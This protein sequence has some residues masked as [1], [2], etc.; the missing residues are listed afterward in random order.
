MTQAPNHQSVLLYAPVETFA[1]ETGPVALALD[2]CGQH[3]LPLTAVMLTAAAAF[4]VTPEGR[5]QQQLTQDSAELEVK[6]QANTAAMT[7]ACAQSG[8]DLNT[9]TEIDYSRGFMPFVD[10]HAR[11]HSLAVIG[12]RDAGPLSE[13]HVSENLLFEAGRPV[14]LVPGTHAARFAARKIAV[15][16][17]NSRPAA[18]AL[19]DALALLPGVE[20]L[21]LIAIGDEKAIHTSIS[22]EQLVQTLSRRGLSVSNVQRPVGGRTIGQALQ[23]T[24]LEAGADLLVM[25]A[26]GHS[27]MRQFFL[28]GATLGVLS[29]LRL[30]VLMAH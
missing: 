17:D 5:T 6:N 1:I 9:V 12:T 4:T 2:L 21:V 18:R 8:I 30:P 11:L 29:N 19:G 10:D 15:A 14:L 23:E 7:Q 25:G 24:A 13:R 28:G 27:R 26:Y 16:W 22:S 3:G 20:E